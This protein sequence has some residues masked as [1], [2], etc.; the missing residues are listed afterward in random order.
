VLGWALG[1]SRFG[2]EK[3][4]DP[5]AQEVAPAVHG[6]RQ[7]R[8]DADE[9]GED[10]DAG[11]RV[12]EADRREGAAAGAAEYEPDFHCFCRLRFG[13][14]TRSRKRSSP[15]GGFWCGLRGE[16]RKAST[17][18]KTTAATAARPA[19]KPRVLLRFSSAKG[20]SSAF[21]SFICAPASS[22]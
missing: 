17:A 16:V 15:R 18:K 8:G 11:R 13:A 19:R 20:F 5:G 22:R 3:P 1:A 14:A 9:A 6:D 4:G 10:G 21:R 12:L 2:R 7:A